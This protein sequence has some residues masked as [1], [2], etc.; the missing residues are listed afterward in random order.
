MSVELRLAPFVSSRILLLLATFFLA[1][2]MSSSSALAAPAAGPSGASKPDFS[3][4]TYTSTDGT[5]ATGYTLCGGQCVAQSAMST[6]CPSGKLTMKKRGM[7]A[8][9]AGESEPNT[10]EAI[11]S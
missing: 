4:N 6:A 10:R 11:R 8:C 3:S 1:L 7:A 2:T 5:C 9:P